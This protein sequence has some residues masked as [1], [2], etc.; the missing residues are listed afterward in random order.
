LF[1]RE[2]A[3]VLALFLDPVVIERIRSSYVL[4][5]AG[6]FSLVASSLCL[7]LT[8]RRR[9]RATLARGPRAVL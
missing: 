1:F 4:W 6:L 9:Q 7:L 2:S 3:K 5:L 8:P